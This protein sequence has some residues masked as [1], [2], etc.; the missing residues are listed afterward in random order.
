MKKTVCLFLMFIFFMNLDSI[1]VAEG[2]E[3]EKPLLQVPVF[4]DSHI[5]GK[6]KVINGFA[7]CKEGSNFQNNDSHLPMIMQ[8]YKELAPDYSAY[9]V[10]GDLVDRGMEDQYDLFMNTISKLENRGAERLFAIGNHE[11]FPYMYDGNATFEDMM[12]LYLNKTGQEKVYYD[13]WIRGFHFIVLGS[14]GLVPNEGYDEEFD[15]LRD[16]YNPDAPY[17]SEEQYS[18]LERTISED[19]KSDKP[20]FVFLH[21]PI[22][23]TVYGSDEYSQNLK[24][25]GRLASIMSKYPQAIL[26][27]GHSHYS[28]NHPRAVYQDGFTMVNTS[29]INYGFYGTTPIWDQFSQGWLMN[30]YHDRVELR[31]RDFIKREW[32]QTVDIQ[33]P[34][35]EENKL[36]QDHKAPYFQEGS[37]VEV[38][39]NQGGQLTFQWDGARD[40]EGIIDKYQILLDGKPIQTHFPRYWEG[41][42]EGKITKTTSNFVSGGLQT[43]EVIGFDAFGNRTSNSLKVEVETDYI[44]GWKKLKD[45]EFQYYWIYIDPQTF[46][47][48]AGWMELDG[49]KYFFNEEG[50]M[51]TGWLKDDGAIYFLNPDGHMQ[52]GFLKG[53]YSTYFFSEDGIMLTGWVN[54]DESWYY[55]NPETGK[56]VKGWLKDQEA[57]YYLNKEGV[58]VTGWVQDKEKWYYLGTDGK[59]KTGWLEDE[60]SRYYL[61]Q[62][63]TMVTGWLYQDS[64]WYYF[65]KSGQMQTGWIELDG[66]RYYMNDSGKMSTGWV[67]DNDKWFFMKA[68][69]TPYTGWLKNKTDWYFLDE[70]GEMKTGWILDGKWYY[71]S[72]SGKMK[73]GWLQEGEHW[74]YLGGTG[75]MMTGWKEISD[76][77]YF[78][79]QSGQMKTG[80]IYDKGSWYYLNEDGKWE[81]GRKREVTDDSLSK[82]IKQQ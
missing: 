79:S 35:T 63:G 67:M 4:S 25:N 65:N 72:G 43:F 33:Y 54:N 77:W 66:Q 29:S 74:Y 21:Q 1:V 11:Y 73:K 31:A 5:C 60:D 53:K 9:A 71:L 44:A 68:D 39:S 52:T 58:R 38:L 62:S 64:D 30:I 69:G 24:M 61:T 22:D 20:V 32:I 80:W 37:G 3:W 51:E 7:M 13:K 18:W 82:S 45:G 70:Q 55:F 50:W 2:E 10:V 59:M 75:A 34:V 36:P 19:A 17:I 15:S 8:Q 76:D 78:F 56:L 26:F 12:N 27:S 49:K 48:Q 57:W 28:L 6:P 46:E 81:S 42:N 23:Y 40:E 14:E 47:K 41:E 16:R